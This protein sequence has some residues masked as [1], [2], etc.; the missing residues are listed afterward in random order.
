MFLRN[1]E[2]FRGK[3]LLQSLFFNKVAGLK[4]ATLLKRRL[5]PKACNVIKKRLRCFPMNFAKFLRTP[6]LQDTSNNFAINSAQF[7]GIT[8]W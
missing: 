3:H 2:K 5:W 4:S 7:G 8:Y 6:Y 1:F